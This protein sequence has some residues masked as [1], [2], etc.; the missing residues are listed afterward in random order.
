[1]GGGSQ[2]LAARSL[3]Y[4]PVGATAPE[5][6]QWVDPPSGFR[7]HEQTNRVGRGREEWDVASSDLMDW[8][9]KIRS[10][11]AVEPAAGGS[12][13][14]ALGA[15][16]LLI[17]SVGPVPVREPVRIVRVVEQRNRIG[18][19]YGTLEGHPVA[20][21]EAFI[22][23]RA[24]D[25]GIWFTVRSLTRASRGSW[26]LAF[27]L[28]L[29]AQP[30][31]RARYRRALA[32]RRG[33]W[34][35]TGGVKETVRNDYSSPARRLGRPGDE[36]VTEVTG[37]RR[38]TA[39]QDEGV[40]N[41][42]EIGAT[43]SP[44]VL[45]F[46]PAGYRPFE[47]SHRLGSGAERLEIAAAALMTWGVHRSAGIPIVDIARETPRGRSS[48]LPRVLTEAGAAIDATGTAPGGVPYV[49]AG[50]TAAQLLSF[51]PV[52]IKAP[53]KVIY[54]IDEEDRIGF[55]YGSRPG[56][57]MQLEQLMFVHRD[58]SGGVWLTLRSISRANSWKWRVPL[59]YF[60]LR[61]KHYSRRFL[62]ALHPAGGR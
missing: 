61:Q 21:E 51:G 57:P 55:A 41:Y 27:P 5:R 54:V 40:L 13:R 45:H 52:T 31:Y 25:G 34:A 32:V 6:E 23:S 62:T 37:P 26:R 53:I 16:Y 3:T 28:A 44:D 12:R 29:I 9:V 20:G 30:C 24:A 59:A 46:P 15:D 7:V 36:Q 48:P 2:Q 49:T 58:P 22:L 14:V 35:D 47:S 10:G 43:Q 38:G 4:A 39:R 19:A 60:R 56:H 50:T 18:Y 1:M 42:A 11:F 8:A 33:L 17:A